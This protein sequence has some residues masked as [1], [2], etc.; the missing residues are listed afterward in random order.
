MIKG[1]ELPLPL[2]GGYLLHWAD[3]AQLPDAARYGRFR[4]LALTVTRPAT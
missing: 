3:Y 4:Y 2:E 1:K